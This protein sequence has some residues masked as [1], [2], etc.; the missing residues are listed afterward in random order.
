M[1]DIAITQKIPDA[2]LML[3]GNKLPKQNLIFRWDTDDS[4]A[5]VDRRCEKLMAN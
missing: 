3:L 2:F 5:S 4:G 1:Y